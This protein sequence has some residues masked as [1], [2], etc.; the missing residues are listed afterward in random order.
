EDMRLVRRVCFD[1][2]GQLCT[3]PTGRGVA[4][5]RIAGRGVERLRSRYI[6]LDASTTLVHQ[7][8]VDACEWVPRVA[9]ASVYRER[10]G[11]ILRDT[12]ALFIERAQIRTREEF[13]AI[14]RSLQK[15]APTLVVVRPSSVR[16]LKAKR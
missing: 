8:N 5:F 13:T 14:A 16:K 6:L 9:C 2:P 12:E 15:C 3:T 7:P 11:G 4:R 10:L 1:Q